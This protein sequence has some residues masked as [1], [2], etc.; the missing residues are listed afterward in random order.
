MG[1]AISNEDVARF[2][3]SGIIQIDF[4]FD[5][6]LL[7]EIIDAVEPL[8]PLAV[9]RGAPHA[10]RLQD[11]WCEIEGCRR[12]AT[13]QRVL[14]VLQVLFARRPLPYQTL[15]FPYPTSQPVHTDTIHFATDPAGYHAAVWVALED[16]TE[17][18]GALVYYPGTHERP[19]LSML[20]LGLRPTYDDY[21]AYEAKLAEFIESEG[22]KPERCC[23]KKGE[24]LIWDAKLFHGGPAG[25]DPSRSRHSQVTHYTFEGCKY[26]TP[27][28]SGPVYRSYRFPQWIPS[29]PTEPR[30]F[31]T[32]K[33]LSIPQRI[34]R[35][36]TMYRYR[37]GD[38]LRSLRG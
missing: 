19:E 27:L 15:N 2:H 1:F 30:P 13:D 24:A 31:G 22:L 3:K 8:Y 23:L 34:V 33:P 14:D 38:L 36:L 32:E 4:G 5:L 25:T 12:L 29:E 37:A 11:A 16:I 20:D 17:D 21:P 26:Y 18:N 7:D 9:E 35:K 6:S 10:G 28:T